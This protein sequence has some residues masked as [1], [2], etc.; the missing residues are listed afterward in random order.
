MTLMSHDGNHASK[1][2]PEPHLA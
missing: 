1:A 2:V